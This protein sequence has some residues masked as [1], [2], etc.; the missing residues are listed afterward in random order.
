LASL[1][2]LAIPAIYAVI[3]AIDFSSFRVR[4]ELNIIFNTINSSLS[5]TLLNNGTTNTANNT[6]HARFRIPGRGSNTSAG[7]RGET[8]APL[9][10][11]PLN[12]TTRREPE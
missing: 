4:P 10:E 1:G 8:A 5:S 12:E 6:I 11:V 2:G 3:V 9:A 7:T